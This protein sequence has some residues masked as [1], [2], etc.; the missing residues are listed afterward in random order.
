MRLETVAKDYSPLWPITVESLDQDTIIGANVS[1]F[2]YL[3]KQQQQMYSEWF[4]S[5]LSQCDCNLF[6]YSVERGETKTTLERDSFWNLGEVVNKFITGS[7]IPPA[8]ILDDCSPIFSRSFFQLIYRFHDI[9]RLG[10]R[11]T[12]CQ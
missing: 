1:L 12:R 4:L 3:T 5:H 2:P 9:K 7:G 10:L 11:A 6:T 8:S